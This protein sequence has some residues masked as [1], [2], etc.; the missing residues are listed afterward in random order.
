MAK[1]PKSSHFPLSALPLLGPGVAD[2]EGI[3]A[4]IA[5]AVEAGMNSEAA[6]VVCILPESW[7]GGPLWSYLVVTT[8]FRAAIHASNACRDQSY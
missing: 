5:T 7:S 1:G 3:A 8:R 4:D 6:F 2:G